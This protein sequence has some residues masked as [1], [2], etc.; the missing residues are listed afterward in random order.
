[1]QLTEQERIV[2]EL[3][4]VQCLANPAYLQCK[5][6]LIIYSTILVVLQQKG[7]LEDAKF[8]AYLEYLQYWFRPEYAQHIQ[9]SYNHMDRS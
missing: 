9:Y 2:V 7:L 5:F 8:L 4:F 6:S 3:E 1:M